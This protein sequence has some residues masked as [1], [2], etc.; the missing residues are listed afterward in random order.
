MKIQAST[1][2]FLFF[3]F[4]GYLAKGQAVNDSVSILPGYT[5]QTFYSLTN[6]DVATIA[7]ADWDLAFDASSFGS[8]IRINGAMGCELYQYANGDTSDWGNIDTSGLGNWPVLYN[9][10]TAWSIGAFNRN[11]DNNFDLGWGTYSV[12]THVVTGDKL[13]LMKLSNGDWKQIWIQRLEG[14]TFYFRHANL[15]GTGEVNL[16]VAKADYTD[17]NFAYYS[18]GTGNFAD[19]EP[20]SSSW[21]LLFTRYIGELAPFVYYGVSGVLSSSGVT[22]A[23]VPG[24][25]PQSNQWNGQAYDDDLNVIG[26]DW[27]DFDFQAG[28]LI[29]DSL[30]YFIQDLNEVIWRINFTGFGGS[31]NGNFI[32][33]KEQIAVSRDEFETWEL[34]FTPYPNPT[35][36][37]HFDIILE[38]D[39]R[40]LDAGIKIFDLSGRMVHRQ[41]LGTLGTGLF[42]IPVEFAAQESGIY[43]L[44]LSGEGFS[45]RKRL[46]VQ[47]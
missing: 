24:V 2:A 7:A 6:G 26:Y 44:Q 15:D 9:S 42:Q 19:L 30:V 16:N 28:W 5:N 21:D 11:T 3:A 8:S 14:G 29:Q 43:I 23:E 25:D 47:H 45:A 38:S 35:S 10:D 37:G 4:A 31:A 34:A 27:K 20:Q 39:R 12:I 17:R 36:G 40:L 41:E 22:V 13:F 18:F 1:L 33:N 46:V 32:F